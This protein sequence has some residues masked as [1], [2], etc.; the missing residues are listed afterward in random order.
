[1]FPKG[2]TLVI[3][4]NR[5]LL[6]PIGLGRQAHTGLF[7]R[8]FFRNPHRRL[9]WSRGEHGH[10][11]LGGSSPSDLLTVGK[12]I[13]LFPLGIHDKLL[14]VPFSS[15]APTKLHLGCTCM[16]RDTE[17]IDPPAQ[18]YPRWTNQEI[19]VVSW[20]ILDHWLTIVFRPWV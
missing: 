5:G 7:S 16:R 20:L 6:G 3:T 12:G 14:G 13:P 17:S 2:P 4:C 1:M 18:I 15:K 19:P 8:W 10:Q 9:I 11:D